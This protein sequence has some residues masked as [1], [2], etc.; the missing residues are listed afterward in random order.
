MNELL[1]FLKHYGLNPFNI[2]FQQDNDPKNAFK[3]V[4]KWLG[5]QMFRTMVCLV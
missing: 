1:D 5:E 4:T 3:K 2:T